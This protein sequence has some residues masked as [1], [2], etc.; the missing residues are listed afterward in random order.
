TGAIIEDVRG[1]PFV[2][3]VSN[4]PRSGAVDRRATMITA[5]LIL[6]QAPVPAPR[7]VLDEN[8]IWTLVAFVAVIAVGALAINLANRLRKRQGQDE[9][10]GDQMGTFREL[11]QRGELSQEEYDRIKERLHSR[12]RQELNLPAPNKPETPPQPPTPPVPPSSPTPDV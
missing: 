5:W 11:Y 10:T 1:T 9:N 12:L 7:W 8:V 3:R 4:V 2:G 6:A